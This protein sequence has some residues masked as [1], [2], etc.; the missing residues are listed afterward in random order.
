M[1]GAIATPL[2]A[3]REGRAQAPSG[4]PIVGQLRGGT[5]SPEREAPFVQGMREYG[6]E[7]G[8]DYDIA[9]RSTDGDPA[10][11]P[12]LIAE[13]IALKPAVIVAQSTGL[14]VGLKKATNTIPIVGLT[15]TDPVGLG[16]AS[17]ITHPGGNV[18][19]ILSTSASTAKLVEVL[20]QIV[21][22][23]R[24]VGVLVNPANA[25][26]WVY[27]PEVQAQFDALG[28][29]RIHG[30]AHLAGEIAPAIQAL[31]EQGIDALQIGA[32]PLFTQEMK[33]IADI[34]LAAKLPTAFTFRILPE[35]GGLMS[36]GTS[37]ADHERRCGVYAAKILKGEK[38]GDLPI[39]QQ[40]K[41]ELVINMKTA[42][43]LGLT[44]PPIVLARADEI[45]E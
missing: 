31:V 40:A 39:E 17:S 25:A 32:D 36:Y 23:A 43:A 26:H 14:V 37:I 35:S 7:E 4:R 29:T 16:L 27:I 6:L 24:K 5:W 19:G 21:P 20:L 45:I 28:V 44:V 18:T 11:E 9:V 38:P 15:L 42:K 8:R 3:L 2:A 33:E 10:R 12:A 34:A 41:V 30:R 1:T 22:N 13:L